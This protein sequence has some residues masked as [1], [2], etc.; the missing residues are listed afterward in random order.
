[1]QTM[2]SEQDVIEYGVR[3]WKRLQN[4]G[5]WA[6]WVAIGRAFAA[7]RKEAMVL[8][9]TNEPKGS[10]Y[11]REFGDWLNR[12][13]PLGEIDKTIRKRL[14]DCLDNLEAIE[15]WRQTIP[16]SKILTLN[17]P[18]TVWRHWTAATQ[19][20]QPKKEDKPKRP[21]LKEEV[22]RLQEEADAAHERARKAEAKLG[23]QSF[24]IV[25]DDPEFIAD[26]IVAGTQ[27]MGAADRAKHLETLAKELARYAKEIR[28]S[29][30]KPSRTKRSAQVEAAL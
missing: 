27:S 11:N 24:S 22:V 26:A 13:Q 30:P 1:M 6:D 12:H 4:G 28:A 10:S 7:G 9:K 17:S 29:V 8:A 16:T 25:K 2:N 15:A 14:F 21:T 19:T 3:T 20:D 5:H 18:L 23:S